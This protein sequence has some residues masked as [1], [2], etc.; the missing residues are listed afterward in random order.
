MSEERLPI[1]ADEEQTPVKKAK[2]K[3]RKHSIS[4]WFREMRSELKKVV[5]PTPKQIVNNTAVALVVMIVFAIVVWGF[6]EVASYGV[7]ALIS[8]TG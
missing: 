4:R 2:K 6:D 1:P 7:K 5:W 8:I 3:G